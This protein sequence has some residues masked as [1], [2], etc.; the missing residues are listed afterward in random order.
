MSMRKIMV[1]VTVQKTCQRLIQMGAMLKEREEDEMFV[2][3]VA[4]RDGVLMSA[5]SDNEAL[6]LLYNSSK[7]AGA[8]H[9][10]ASFGQYSG[11]L[12]RICFT[13]LHNSYYNG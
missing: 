11:Y 7:E 13:K 3:H 6:E 1:C 4:P 8:E 5:S 12:G 10:C 9:V 2:V